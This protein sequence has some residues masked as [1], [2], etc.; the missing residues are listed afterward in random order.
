MG[1]D[2]GSLMNGLLYYQESAIRT[3]RD[4]VMEGIFWRKTACVLTA[5][6]HFKR[7]FDA[8]KRAYMIFRSILGEED[9]Y[10]KGSSMTLKYLMRKAIE[11]SIQTADND[12][13][14]KDKDIGMEKTEET[15][16]KS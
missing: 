5:L 15:I 11:Q 8:E 3:N 1:Y 9:E 6:N 10:T 14:K 4:R 16:H 13:R 12:K 7:A 2:I